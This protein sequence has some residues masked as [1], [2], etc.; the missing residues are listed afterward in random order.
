MV[1]KN[2]EHTQ[3][4]NHLSFI[5]FTASDPLILGVGVKW[6]TFQRNIR[7]LGLKQ[8]G[9]LSHDK[10]EIDLEVRVQILMDKDA[11]KRVVLK[12]FGKP[13]LHTNFLK[14]MA[15][16]AIIATCLN[17]T[18]VEY[19]SERSS[20]DKAMFKSLQDSINTEDFGATVEFFQL[21]TITLPDQ[22]NEVI[23]GESL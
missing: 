11:L 23:I 19:Y 5:L 20:I 4:V 1:K 13:E 17:F 8:L 2:K 3:Q 7:D 18:A 6:F 15:K 16:C 14:Y 12:K 22:L 9:C 21:V 10:V